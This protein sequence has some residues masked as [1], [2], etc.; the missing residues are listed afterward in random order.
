MQDLTINDLNGEWLCLIN[1]SPFIYLRIKQPGNYHLHF[2][3]DN[4]DYFGS[5]AL[6]Y[7][8]RNTVE[9]NLDGFSVVE[10]WCISSDNEIAIKINNEILSFRRII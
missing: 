8:E 9:M 4:K 6:M 2:H 7:T 1:N 10:L 3:S 5:I